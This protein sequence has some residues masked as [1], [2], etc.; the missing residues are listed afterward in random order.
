MNRWNKI[1]GKY[2]CINSSESTTSSEVKKFLNMN[3]TEEYNDELCGKKSKK[4]IDPTLI[5]DLR[6]N[7][8]SS[9][10]SS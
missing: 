9:R 10:T 7:A 5:M 8:V 3:F 1:S 2:S 4:F 6:H